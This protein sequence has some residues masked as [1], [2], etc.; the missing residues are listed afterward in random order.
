MP[1]ET[2]FKTRLFFQSDY[3]KKKRLVDSWK[4]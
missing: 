3:K 4:C 2:S 1:R